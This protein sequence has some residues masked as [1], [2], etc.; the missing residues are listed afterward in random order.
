MGVFIYFTLF[1]FSFGPRLPCA[2]SVVPPPRTDE[3][4]QLVPGFSF[5]IQAF[6]HLW[7]LYKETRENA[8]HCHHSSSQV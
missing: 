6:F 4:I 3:A 5:A 1:L 8:S 7:L 2:W